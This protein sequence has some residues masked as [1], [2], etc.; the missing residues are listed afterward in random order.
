MDINDTIILPEEKRT[1]LDGIV[2]KMIQNKESDE[3]I[4]MVVGDF[5]N[6]HGL[7]KK[8][9]SGISSED[10]QLKTPGTDGLSDS[11]SVDKKAGLRYKKSVTLSFR[12][13]NSAEYY[14]LTK[15]IDVSRDESGKKVKVRRVP[16]GSI[17]NKNMIENG[18]SGVKLKPEDYAKRRYVEGYYTDDDDNKGTLLVPFDDVKQKM[19]ENY[20]GLEETITEL[21]NK[22]PADIN[23]LRKKYGY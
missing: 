17:I 21:E 12:P 22:K 16:K 8:D 7:K 2:Q 14:Y 3:S 5:K 4:Q 6:I 1:Q 11:E 15:D 9:D 18:M 19:A 23:M 10:S 13:I 20:V